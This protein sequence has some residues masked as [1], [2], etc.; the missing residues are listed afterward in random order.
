MQAQQEEACAEAAGPSS[1]AD[2]SAA[3]TAEAARPPRRQPA[4]G[5]GK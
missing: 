2:L 5:G 3:D 4:R 1:E